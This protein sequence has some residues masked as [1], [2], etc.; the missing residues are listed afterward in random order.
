MRISS[1]LVL[2][3]FILSACSKDVTLNLPEYENKPVVFA[4]AEK[5]KKIKLT[6]KQSLP[7]LS[8][9]QSE[10]IET[11]INLF[12]DGSFKEKFNYSNG[13]YSSNYIPKESDTLLIR[14][15]WQNKEISSEVVVPK[16]V[17]I[18]SVQFLE[19]VH[20][21]TDNFDYYSGYK[22]FFDDKFTENE[23]Y[24]TAVKYHFK[25]NTQT[26]I[27]MPYFYYA[28][29][30]VLVNENILE[31]ETNVLVFS[32]NLFNS[33]AASISFADL[34]PYPS[35]DETLKAVNIIL[36]KTSKSYYQYYKS[37]LKNQKS[38]NYDVWQGG[39][40]FY[41]ENSNITNGFGVFKALTIDSLNVINLLPENFYK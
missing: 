1:I 25:N 18:D 41:N 40:P 6:V 4:I 21:D 35:Q 9:S 16:Q 19:N 34:K 11:E 32:D 24:E 26:K 2:A 7:V 22:I 15:E 5:G 12:V 33:M 37:Y 29:D 38:Q 13:L 17:K 3:Y 8:N 39:S 14:F 20:F 36:L 23:Y 28:N 30:P 10:N 27:K 31:Y